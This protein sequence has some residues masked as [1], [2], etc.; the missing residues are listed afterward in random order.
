VTIPQGELAALGT[1]CAWS[2]GYVF[3]SIA[4]RRIGPDV[5]NRLRLAM[6]LVILLL[7]H[8]LVYGIPLPLHVEAWRLGW[9]ALAGVVGFVLSDAMLFRALDTL[10]PQRTSLVMA[11]VPVASSLLAWGAFGERLSL[12]EMGA[13][14]L[15]IGGIALVLWKGERRALLSRRAYLVGIGLAVASS[16]AQASRYVLSKEG[17]AGGFPV[18]STNVLQILSATLIIWLLAFFQKK[19]RTTVASLA[20]R[21]GAWASLGGAA[22]GPVVGVT[23]SLVALNLAPVGV[24]STLMALS[25]VFL[26]PLS[27]VLFKEPI[28]PRAVA[29]TLVAMAGV[30]ILF[31]A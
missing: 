10:G 19:A 16:C 1:S 31:L 30:A 15:V 9:L 17:M 26:L 6:A 3:F 22:S 11:L 27:R 5:L 25:P 7:L 18:L 2:V 12:V 24:A 4:V 23:L 28:R 29:G 14:A 20:D 8:T 13:I 21:T